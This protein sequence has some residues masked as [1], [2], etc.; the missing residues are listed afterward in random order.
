MS[1]RMIKEVLNPRDVATHCPL[2]GRAFSRFPSD[3]EHIYPKWIQHHHDLWNRRLNIPNFIGKKYKTI[4]ITVCTRCNRKTFGNLETRL[5]PLLT[6]ADPFASA[7]PIENFA[8]AVWLGKIFWLLL[9]K[10]HSVIDFRTRDLPQ[11]DR[12]LPNELLPAT[13]FLGMFERAFATRKTM[14]ACYDTDPPIPEF[15]Y[16]EPYSL[17]RFR[18]DTRDSRFEAFD[19]TDSPIGLGASMRTNN[20]GLI[21]LFDGGL[22]RRFRGHWYNS[23]LGETLHPIQFA[24][25]TARMMYDQTVLHDD[26]KRVTYYWKET[27]N[28]VISQIHTPRNSNPYLQENH[29]PKRLASYIGRHIFND[30]AQILGP[31]GA[32]ASCIYNSEK[33]FL[34]YPVTNA[35]LEAARADP[36]R[37]VL[38]PMETKWRRGNSGPQGES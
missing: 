23:L 20:L 25:V 22:H 14:V 36:N 38:G 5:A 4:K 27:L 26:A 9:R 21:C 37:T 18:I 10:S 7:A 19:F 6:G 33:C 29:D 1:L 2:C 8:L 24:E 31:D 30:P 15:F 28:S 11:P 3:E 34:R 16:E 12:I 13:L 32:I 17:Y 35:E